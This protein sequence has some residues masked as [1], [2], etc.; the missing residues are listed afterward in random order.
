MMRLALFEEVL[1]SAPL[2]LPPAVH[3]IY[4]RQGEV[5]LD[6]VPL[7]PD[8]AVLAK[9]AAR[10]AGTGEVWR[11]EVSDAAELT[12]PHEYARLVLAHPLARDPAMPFVLRLDRVD[13]PPEGATPKHGHAGPGIRRLLSGRLLAEVGA[14]AHRI[15][16]GGAWFE[17]GADPVIGR[18]MA[19]GSAF[20]RCMV[21]DA[22]L[23]GR[24]TFRAWTEEDAAKPRSASYRLF[25]D[26]L[27]AL[28]AA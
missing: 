10:L 2:T 25:F 23:L 12:A 6:G 27:T 1:D 26:T 19:P 5:T 7:T 18:V 28:D 24:P 15:D 21:L 22:E 16:A 8:A 20:I 13:F 11:F 14:Q 3:G 9:G 17:T 4:L